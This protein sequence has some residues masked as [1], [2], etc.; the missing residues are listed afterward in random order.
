[1]DIPIILYLCVNVNVKSLFFEITVLNVERDKL[2]T[3]Y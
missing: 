1:M 3:Y 2:Y